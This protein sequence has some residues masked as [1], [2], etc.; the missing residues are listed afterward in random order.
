MCFKE[1]QVEEK[2]ID[3]PEFPINSKRIIQYWNDE[4]AEYRYKMS[5]Y[6]KI[7][8]FGDVWYGWDTPNHWY[9]KSGDWAEKNAKHYG[10]EIERI[11]K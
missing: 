5:Y 8:L 7:S 2:T 10:I 9:D 1:R 3:Q 4:A 11:N 6:N